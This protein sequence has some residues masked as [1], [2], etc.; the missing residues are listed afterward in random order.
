MTRIATKDPRGNPNGFVVPL[1][2]VDH[3]PRIDQAY[4][5]TVLPGAQKG[6]HCHM[7]RRGHYVCIRGAV[8]I[9]T[10]DP[11]GNY[12]SFEMSAE[13][14]EHNRGLDIPPGTVSALYNLG[15]EEAW[16]LNMPS[17]PWRSD[18]QDEWPVNDWTYEPQ[19]ASAVR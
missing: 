2:H 17:P 16:L 1:W 15:D 7:K 9:V 5:T 11:E 8:L 14:Q 12:R 3:G 13:T 4:L 10:R 18:D 19:L 6:P